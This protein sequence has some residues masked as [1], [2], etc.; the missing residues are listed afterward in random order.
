V[1]IE[2]LSGVLNIGISEAFN[3][4]APERIPDKNGK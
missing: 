4:K 3:V 2:E 1:D